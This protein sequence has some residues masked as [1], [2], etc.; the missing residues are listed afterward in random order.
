M[1]PLLLPS[2][3]LVFGFP[4]KGKKGI[5]MKLLDLLEKNKVISWSDKNGVRD[6]PGLLNLLEKNKAISWSDKNGVRDLPGLLN[7]LE[8]TKVISWGEKNGVSGL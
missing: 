6:L 1:A 5:G 3:L 2:V 4:A 8:K 7:L